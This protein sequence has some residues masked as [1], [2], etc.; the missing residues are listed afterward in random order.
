MP[1][2]AVLRDGVYKICLA[3]IYLAKTTHDVFNVVVLVDF[4]FCVFVVT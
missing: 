1:H 3:H 2:R 4:R